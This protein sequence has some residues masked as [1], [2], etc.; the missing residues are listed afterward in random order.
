MNLK[1]NLHAT[2]TTKIGVFWNVSPC[3]LVEEYKRFIIV[4][5]KSWPLWFQ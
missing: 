4:V 2:S 3:S 5:N 1:Y